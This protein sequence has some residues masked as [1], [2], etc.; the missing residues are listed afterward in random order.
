MSKLKVVVV[1]SEKGEVDRIDLKESDGDGNYAELEHP[2][3]Q[4]DVAKIKA[5]HAAL[6]LV[7]RGI[8]DTDDVLRVVNKPKRSG[9]HSG[10][11]PVAPN[12]LSLTV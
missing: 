5:A 6:T 2:W 7:A 8:S 9:R 11:K 10:K 12:D 3:T 1:V 4:K